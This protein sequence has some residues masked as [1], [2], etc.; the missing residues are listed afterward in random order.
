M[1]DAAAF[2]AV[3]DCQCGLCRSSCQWTPG[4]FLPSEIEPLAQALGLT[5]RESPAGRE[6]P[7]DP[8]G[9]CHW[10]RE[11]RCA[12]HTLGKPLEC[13]RTHHDQPGIELHLAMAQAWSA[14]QEMIRELLGRAPEAKPLP[15]HRRRKVRGIK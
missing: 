10:Y 4:W 8:V 12:I 3:P 2:P 14:H 11:G 9:R 13:A 6:Y 7:G 1:I 5:V 15:R